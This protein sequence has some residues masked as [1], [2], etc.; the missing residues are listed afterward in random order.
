MAPSRPEKEMRI[1][2]ELPGASEKDIEVAL[3]DD[4]LTIRG[5]KK[6][7][8]KDERENMHFAKHAFG[9]FQRSLRLP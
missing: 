1:T 6:L 4:V 8:R 7:E 2:A 9:T 3:D 5:E